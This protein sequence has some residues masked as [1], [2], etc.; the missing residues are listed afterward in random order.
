MIQLPT[1]R[2][3]HFAVT[4]IVLLA[5]VVPLSLPDLESHA[6]TPCNIDS[7]PSTPGVEI[8][9]LACESGLQRLGPS[10]L[11]VSRIV[12]NPGDSLPLRETAYT[13]LL[14]VE[15][16][17]V[18]VFDAVNNRETLV[19]AGWYYLLDPTEHWN[20]FG[21]RN[22]G[23][24][25]ASVLNAVATRDAIAAQ[26]E[27]GDMEFPLLGTSMTGTL[28]DVRGYMA[29]GTNPSQITL[30]RVTMQPGAGWDFHNH[31]GASAIYVESGQLAVRHFAPAS[32]RFHM[33]THSYEFAAAEAV[34]P[35]DQDTIVSAGQ[36]VIWPN[37]EV[38]QEWNAFSDPVTFIVLTVGPTTD[39]ITERNSVVEIHSAL[40][41][42]GYTGSSY[43]E[44]CHQQMRDGVEV[45]LSAGL[46]TLA[47]FERSGAT[48][49]V[50]VE[51]DAYHVSEVPTNLTNSYIYCSAQENVLLEQHILGSEG[52][53]L[54]IPPASNVVCDWY[55]IPSV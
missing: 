1:A 34:I 4:A 17:E 47:G 52:F 49:F 33:G 42:A 9:L 20:T 3:L 28:L 27:S 37:S 24:A 45:V 32:A 48:L 26:G 14:Y 54:Q 16:G 35:S 46:R 21:L 13:E 55:S 31:V 50:N 39:Q 41:P 30:A 22:D 5:L 15:S 43:F 38:H 29:F 18:V 44:V 53:E 8:Q 51:A 40:C 25:P 2:W 10:G 7:Q 12:L 19:A 23:G 11:S 6:S 36:Y